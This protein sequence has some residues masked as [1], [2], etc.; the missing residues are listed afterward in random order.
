MVNRSFRVPFYNSFEG[1][2]I[3]ARIMEKLVLVT[4]DKYQRLLGAQSTKDLEPTTLKRKSVPEP[5]PGKCNS[6]KRMFPLGDFIR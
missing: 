2:G 5:P 4:Y 1:F 6:R 3:G